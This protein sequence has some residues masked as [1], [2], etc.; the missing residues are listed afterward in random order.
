MAELEDYEW[1]KS[2]D[3]RRFLADLRA[4]PCLDPFRTTQSLR[5]QLPPNRVSVLLEQAELFSYAK[6]KFRDAEKWVWTKTLLEQASDEVT[7]HETA[8]DFP[9]DA[10]VVDLCCGAGADSV[11]IAKRVSELAALDLSPI[12]CELTRQNAESHAL[13]FQ[14]SHRDASQVTI[15]QHQFLHLDPD[16]R[17][18]GARVSRLDGMTPTWDQIQLLLKK[19]HGASLKLAPGLRM[20]LEE[21]AHPP[22]TIR[23]LSRDGS[24]KQQRWYWGIER[25]PSHSIIVSTSF[26]RSEPS[27]RP[28]DGTL[29]TMESGLQET[30][31]HELFAKEVCHDTSLVRVIT[32]QIGDF[33]ADY[34]PGLRASELAC[35]FADRYRLRLLG[36]DH[37]YLTSSRLETHP[38]IRWYRVIEELPVDKKQLRA[39]AKAMSPFDWELKSRGVEI[40][41]DQIRKLLARDPN[42]SSRLAILFTQVNGRYRAIA[43]K[44]VH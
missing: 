25:W 32:D 4:Q 12:A 38:M 23:F 5:Q 37:G 11:A 7:S 27:P 9:L 16:R 20:E 28:L 29:N 41:L 31:H 19:C 24:V 33:I 15:G 17:H 2:A 35:A 6:R 3:A 30:W 34:D 14:V 22:D 18:A 43:C 1:L 10:S 21:L 42:S 36:M 8:A 40:D 44:E 26:K 13:G 39:F